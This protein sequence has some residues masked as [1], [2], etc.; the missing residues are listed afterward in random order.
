MPRLNWS[1]RFAR[2]FKRLARRNPQ[3]RLLLDQTLSQLAE[4]PFHP[5][6]ETHKLK[7]NLSGTWSCSIDYSNRILF[8]FIENPESSEEEIWLSTV[9]SHDD[10]Y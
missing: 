5:S 8:E 7:G 1:S 9:G 4:N 2:D 6:L 10:V 3:L